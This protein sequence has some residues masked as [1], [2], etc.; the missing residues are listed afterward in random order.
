MISWQIENG[1][2]SVGHNGF[3]DFHYQELLL[4]Y[5]GT[6]KVEVDEYGRT[7]YNGEELDRLL[8]RIRHIYDYFE[9][10]PAVWEIVRRDYYEASGVD[11]VPNAVTALTFERIAVLQILDQIIDAIVLAQN[12]NGTLIFFGD[13]LFYGGNE[14]MFC[15][16]NRIEWEYG[17]TIDEVEV[18]PEEPSLLSA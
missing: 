8:L 11:R 12:G 13:Q 15:T 18:E 2:G 6:G 3:P 17:N 9:A 1:F 5:F 16:V 14:A 10:A 4:P 7:E